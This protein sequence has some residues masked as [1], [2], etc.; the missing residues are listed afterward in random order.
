MSIGEVFN[1]PIML[2]PFA[3]LIFVIIKFS[4]VV[5]GLR[6]IMSVKTILVVL[7]NTFFTSIAS[8]FV[9]GIIGG[10]IAGA[11]AWVVNKLVT[12]EIG[13]AVGFTYNVNGSWDKSKNIKL[14]AP[15]AT[16]VSASAA[17]V[18]L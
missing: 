18:K 16:T 17:K 7:L 10:P 3:F 6:K 13:K 2:L 15:A 1:V 14:P 11:V 9:V 4:I 8:L 5:I 12:P